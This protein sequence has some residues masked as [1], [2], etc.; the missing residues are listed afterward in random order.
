[1]IMNRHKKALEVLAR[2]TVIPAT[3]LAIDENRRFDPEQQKLLTG[4]YLAAGAGGIATAVHSTQFAI[5]NPEHAMLEPVLSAVADEIADFEAKS[6]KTIVKVSGVCGRT[7]QA[8]REAEIARSYGYDALLASPGGLSEL[9]EAEILERTIAIGEVLPVIGFYLQPAVGGRIFSRE[10]WEKLCEIPSV[11]AIKCAPF[12]RYLTLDVVRACALSSRAD[13]ITLYTGNDDNIVI[14][15]LTEFLFTS[16][17]RTYTARFKGG[18]LGHWSVWT[19]RVV[20]LF[21]T[22]RSR[23]ADS[24]LLTLA[25]EITDSN[26]AVF[27]SANN[28]AGCIAGIHEVL[29][30]QGLMKGIWC[31]DPQETLSPGQ[32]EELDRVCAM[33]PHLTDDEFVKEYLAGR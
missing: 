30:R 24:E 5:R 23:P 10:Y 20:E 19:K 6:G 1:M 31:L 29:R 17:G 14:D 32:S 33:Y 27:D 2:G 18:L 22:L 28:Y 3:P 12:N 25:A 26:G 21:E 7:N 4:Y 9:S 13:E 16:D 15:L 11:V 8:V